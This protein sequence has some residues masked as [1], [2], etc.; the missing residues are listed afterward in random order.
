MN[1]TKEQVEVYKLRSSDTSIG[2][3]DITVDNRGTAGRLSIASDYGKWQYYWG[4]TGCGF[5]EFLTRLNEHYMAEK[6]GADGYFDFEA[7][8]AS[9][10]EGIINDRKDE[11]I[12]AEEA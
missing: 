9:I 6:F 8:I 1:I 11:N 4:S 5:K 3:A 12:E 2:W 7:T 10:K